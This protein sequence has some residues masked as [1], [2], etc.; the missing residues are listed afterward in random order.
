[1]FQVRPKFSLLALFL[2]CINSLEFC[3]FMQGDE[4]A[5][6]MG[7]PFFYGV[8]ELLVIGMYCLGAWKAG[9]TKAPPT[10]PLWK[11]VTVNY[12]VL[13][14]EK[15]AKE[16]N[17]IEIQL[18]DSYVHVE[19]AGDGYKNEEAEKGGPVASCLYYC[20]E[21]DLD[22]VDPP[23]P[24]KDGVTEENKETLAVDVEST[25]SMKSKARRLFWESLG[26]KI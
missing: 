4:L 18:S 26:Y 12:E 24:K 17:N 1:M 14:A 11:V 23:A 20:H 13:L 10:E 5:E 21:P 3:F 15:L 6:A 7:V 9:W 25:V 8:V 2:V 22:D 19:E 16:R